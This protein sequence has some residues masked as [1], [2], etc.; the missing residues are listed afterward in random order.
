[1]DTKAR[2]NATRAIP[3]LAPRLWL[4]FGVLA[5]GAAFA[6]LRP[7]AAQD[8]PV[9]LATA[10]QLR[11][12]VGPIALYPD[13]LVAIVLP[14]STYP[15]QVVQAARFLEDRKKNSSL[16]PNEDWDDSI[17]A[18]LNYPEAL[19]LLN[20]DLDWT[21]DLGTAVLNQRADVLTAVQDFRDE[22]YA[23][24]N[25]KSDNRQTVARTDDAIEIKP[26]D[27]KVIYVP[28]YEPERV[29]V[30]QP[31]PVYYYYPI[32]YPVYYYPYPEHYY[33]STGFFWG[34]NTWF[35]IGWHSH[36]LNVYDPFYY[37]HPYYGW[38]YYN[39]YY[40]RNVY[41]NVNH[42]HSYPNNVWEPR[43]RY[44]GRPVTRS[45]EG[46]VYTADHTP[47]GTHTREGPVTRPPGS[48]PHD[49]GTRPRDG[50][51]PPHDSGT[52]H[53]GTD[54]TPPTGN[55]ATHTPR[56]RSTA[57]RPPMG[58][59]TQANEGSNGR[60]TR[61]QEPNGQRT[62]GQTHQPV[63]RPPGASADASHAEPDQD[64]GQGQSQSQGQRTY[65]SGSGMSQAAE[66]Y[67]APAQPNTQPNT[68]PNVQPRT[69]P[70]ATHANSNSMAR[71]N[72]GVSP[73]ASERSTGMPYESSRSAPPQRQQSFE[74][75]PPPS[76]G[77]GVSAQRSEP[78]GGYHG[79]SG[80]GNGDGGYRGDSGGGNDGGGGSYRG[81]SGGG[82]DGGSRG[83][84]G[85]GG[86]DNGGG[87]HGGG[88]GSEHSRQR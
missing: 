42:Y 12:L 65:R 85:G 74:A 13:D 20:D 57:A 51:T 82:N 78:S 68:Q 10:E 80:G 16:K 31:A 4:A 37:G 46:R 8:A 47:H 67:R 55:D 77:G 7:A 34:V 9:E 84:S 49:G 3:W 1:M 28:Y 62:H 6:A 21:Y 52:P 17:V 30:Y 88:G 33:F 76:H 22:A 60:S 50:G 44:G 63:A 24:G 73:R 83:N 29:V 59:S 48:P 64:H 54:G 56:G 53:H 43:Y 15:L 27:P 61:A 66:R 41:V 26:A 32:A 5:I 35:S 11:E 58:N 75:S 18:L 81:N 69:S 72:P 2:L 39:P 23:A 14:A 38:N 40:V 79:N 71:A 36:Y 87:H 70:G 25:L 45:T 86:G 19:A